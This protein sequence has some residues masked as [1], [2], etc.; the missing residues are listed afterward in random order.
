MTTVTN[1]VTNAASEP[2]ADIR[3]EIL[4]LT[5][6]GPAWTEDDVQIISRTSTLTEVDGSWSLDLIPNSSITPDNTI[7]QAVHYVPGVVNPV[8]TFVVPD[9]AGPHTLV[10]LVQSVPDSLPSYGGSTPEETPRSFDVSANAFGFSITPDTAIQNTTGCKLLVNLVFS[11]SAASGGNLSVAVG[12]TSS[13]SYV[14]V[15]AGVI[16]VQIITFSVIV[17]DGYYLKAKGS[18]AVTLSNIGAAAS[19]VDG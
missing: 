7:Y 6:D 2:L 13:P 12:P 11:L 17:P 14:S 1:I 8:I 9:D 19:W 16:V 18:G 3:V 10:S 4:L 5:G 15:I